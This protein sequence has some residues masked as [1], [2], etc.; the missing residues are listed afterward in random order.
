MS[1]SNNNLI[2]DNCYVNRKYKEQKD[3]YE[4]I[5]Y[6]GF[7]ENINKCKGDKNC[8]LYPSNLVDIESNLKNIVKPCSLCNNLQDQKKFKLT[9]QHVCVPEIYPIVE[10]NIRKDFKPF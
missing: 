4:H 6:P 3:Q 1:R 5:M 8:Q 10:N 7:N 2:Y 9:N